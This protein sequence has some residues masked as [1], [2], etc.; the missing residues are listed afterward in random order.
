LAT[1]LLVLAP[2]AWGQKKEAKGTEISDK[3]F[4]SM[5]SL[6]L[7]DPLHRS[8]PDWARLILL[9]TLQTQSA[10]VVLD[11]D[12]FSWAALGKD[13]EHSLL[14]LAGYLAGNIQ[15]Q[16]NSGVKRNDRYSGV[17]TLFQVY[18]SMQEKA[19]Q[20]KKD[21]EIT[22]VENL[23]ALHQTD[24]LT[25]YLQKLKTKQPAKLSPEAQA[26]LRKL[27]ERR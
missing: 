6:L 8:A 24:R 23:L 7:N 2:A 9:Y 15:S 18:R 27:R 17:L 25:G 11:A 13:D 19:K 3:M 26:E 14:L 10:E 22:T 21:F 4:R 1:L 5:A 20:E 16:L 12:E